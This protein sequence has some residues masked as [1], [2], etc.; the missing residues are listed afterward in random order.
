MESLFPISGGS[1]GFARWIAPPKGKKSAREKDFRGSKTFSSQPI[2]WILIQGKKEIS[3][4]S[5]PFIEEELSENEILLLVEK[6]GSFSFLD[7]PEE[8]I[9]SES[10]GIS[11]K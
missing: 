2:E 10:D 9:Y 8:D 5:K 6:G 4:I 3:P 7:D 1:T 11:L